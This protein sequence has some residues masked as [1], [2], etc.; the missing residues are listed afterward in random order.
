MRRVTRHLLIASAAAAATTVAAVPSAAA[1]PQ[2][3]PSERPQPQIL[4]SEAPALQSTQTRTG[5]FQWNFTPAF[6][7][8]LKYPNAQAQGVND[9]SCVPKTGTQPILLLHGTVANQYDSFARMG[10]ELA[11]DGYCVY[12][13]NYGVDGTSVI[14]QI[15]G[16]YGTTGLPGNTDELTAFAEQV[17]SRTG[18]DEVDMIGWSQGGT[19]INDHIKDVDGQGVDE[20]VTYGATHHGTTASGL[21]LLARQIGGDG[22]V[23]AGLGQAGVDQLRGSDYLQELGAEG[24]TVPGVEYTIV[25]SRYDSITTPYESTFLTA[26]PG[27]TVDNITLQDGCSIDRSSHLSMMYSPRAIDIAKRA[28]DPQG[29]GRLRCVYNAQLP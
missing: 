11:R 24:D 6:A 5:P 1:E 9:Y 21:G 25:A 19:I 23:R 12:S 29:Q 17:R 16:R 15:P 10:P 8:S 3:A 14:S 2:P 28:F 4:E 27:A 18:A 13:F 20:V 22:A 7:Y 26:G